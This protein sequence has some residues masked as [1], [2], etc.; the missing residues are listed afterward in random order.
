METDLSERETTW[1]VI[2]RD[3]PPV[4]IDFVKQTLGSSLIQELIVR[5]PRFFIFFFFLLEME[6]EKKKKK[7][8]YKKKKKKIVFFVDK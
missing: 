1:D 3:L 8:V 2:E 4:E 5:D 6:I 7:I